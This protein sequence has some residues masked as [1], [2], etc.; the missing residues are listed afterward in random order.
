[1]NSFTPKTEF[2]VLRSGKV[3]A[4]RVSCLN[5]DNRRI[6]TLGWEI[7]VHPTLG[8][9]FHLHGGVTGYESFV[10]ENFIKEAYI[11]G[12]VWHACAGTPGRWDTLII[13]AEDFKEIYETCVEC[14][15]EY[16][17]RNQKV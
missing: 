13:G 6:V 2:P 12:Q 15:K 7:Y 5:P 1:M 11:P 3:D 4:I 16:E 9:C 10:L 8:P 14:L 17:T